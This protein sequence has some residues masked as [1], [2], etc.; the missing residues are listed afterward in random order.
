MVPEAGTAF[1]CQ[2]SFRP[3]CYI[4]FY[5]AAL[6]LLAGYTSFFPPAVLGLGNLH[7]LFTRSNAMWTTKRGAWRAVKRL[8]DAEKTDRESEINDVLKARVIC[9][10]KVEK[11]I[12]EDAVDSSASGIDIVV[13][14]V[15]MS[16]RGCLPHC[17]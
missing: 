2:I 5:L 9:L 15:R 4:M 16:F 3:Y 11:T 12:V 17:S 1:V 6:L 10:T 14:L 7:E 13:T 8:H